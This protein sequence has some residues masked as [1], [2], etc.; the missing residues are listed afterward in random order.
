MTTTTPSSGFYNYVHQALQKLN[1]TMD[2][3]NASLLEAFNNHV[4]A[5]N[6][7]L[8]TFMNNY[9]PDNLTI[10]HNTTLGSSNSDV[11]T[12]NA[13]SIFNTDVLFNDQ[14][15]IDTDLTIR[16][17]TVIG[18]DNSDAL[19]IN[20]ESSFLGGATF[21]DTL[22]VIDN[23]IFGTDTTNTV[24]A[25]GSITSQKLIVPLVSG[26]NLNFGNLYN[27]IVY[28]EYNHTDPN[29]YI[30]YP[31]AMIL[32]VKNIDTV[33]HLVY[34]TQTDDDVI[35]PGKTIIYMRSSVNGFSAMTTQL[36]VD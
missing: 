26:N 10:P 3:N 29:I 27:L 23:T 4:I 30:D 7:T 8:T 20:S 35:D 34:R 9:N 16:G 5:M 17:S 11:F 31:Y 36:P 33:G 2:A 14:V 1:E 18:Q 28:R 19:T 25:T 24:T 21:H 13:S 12:V 15:I 22:H 6:D 32:I